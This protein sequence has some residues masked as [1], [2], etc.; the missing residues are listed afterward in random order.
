MRYGIFSD[1][2]ANLEAFEAVLGALSKEAV[3]K[4]IC[5]GDI[6][7][8]GADP[9]ECI[10][11]LNG[12][13]VKSVAGNHDAGCIGKLPLEWFNH[14]AKEALAWTR[15]IIGFDDMIFLRSLRLVEEEGP[16]TIVH[17][18]LNRPER[19][20]YMLDIADAFH[21]QKMCKTQICIVGHTHIPCII[22]FEGSSIRVIDKEVAKIKP[23]CKYVINVGSVGQPRDGISKTCFCVYDDELSE[24]YI[25][26]AEYDIQRTQGKILK[27][28][29]PRILADRLAVGR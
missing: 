13:N 20:N 21:A 17:G 28:K 8:Y 27:N 6:V 1:V 5:A 9:V 2:H 11:R 7:G 14:Y 24:F 19:F 26:R 15:G 22:E 3:D 4:Y 12:L 23:G 18:T 29:L 25:K 10:R 16:F